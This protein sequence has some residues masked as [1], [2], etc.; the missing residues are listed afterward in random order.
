MDEDVRRRE[1]AML[2]RCVT[3]LEAYNLL[4]LNAATKLR[5]SITNMSR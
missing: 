5:M 3:T 2:G 1:Q 4:S